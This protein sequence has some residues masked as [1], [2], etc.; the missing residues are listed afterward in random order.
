M[1]NIEL[2]RPYSI[3]EITEVIGIS[4]GTFRHKRDA[5]L[6][7]LSAAYEYEVEQ[8]IGKPTYFTFTKQIGEFEKPL[9]E[10]S[11]KKTDKIIR[12][13]INEA[14]EENPEQTAADINRKAWQENSE[15]TTLKLKPSTT[16]EYIR[17]KL[18][19]IRK[20]TEH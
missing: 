13:I 6:S 5:Y 10:N 16:G 3:K 14:L 9:R 11:R 4:E 18:K 19:E 17:L 1:I 8:S 12:K 20:E 15:I 7:Q 2:N